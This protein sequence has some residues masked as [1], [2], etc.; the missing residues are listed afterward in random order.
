MIYYSSLFL[1]TYQMYLP[2]ITSKML[3]SGES[4]ITLL[5]CLVISAA[6]TLISSRYNNPVAKTVVGKIQAPEEMK[7]PKLKLKSC[8]GS[9]SFCESLLMLLA[10]CSNPEAIP[11]NAA[12]PIS[13]MVGTFGLVS[14]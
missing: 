11:S 14:T 13:N 5:N 4:S 9:N 3:P 6:R 2:K 1:L 7:F 10:I 8:L 12:F